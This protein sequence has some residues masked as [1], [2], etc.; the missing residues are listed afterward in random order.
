MNSNHAYMYVTV[1]L[2]NNFIYLHIFTST[3]VMDGAM[4]GLGGATAPPNFF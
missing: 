4:V 2:Q 1:H 3:D